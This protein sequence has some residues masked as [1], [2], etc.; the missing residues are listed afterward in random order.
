[1]IITRAGWGEARIG[2]K[3]GKRNRE[4]TSPPFRYARWM[5]HGQAKS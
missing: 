4:S 3:F 5:G 2:G 1:M